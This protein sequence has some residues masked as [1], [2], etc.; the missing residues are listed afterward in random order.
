MVRDGNHAYYV[1]EACYFVS[2]DGHTR[3]KTQFLYDV[4][5]IKTKVVSEEEFINHFVD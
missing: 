2:E 5:G 4:Y 1:S 3:E